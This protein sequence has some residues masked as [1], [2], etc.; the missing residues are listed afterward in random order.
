MTVAD[1]LNTLISGVNV[2]YKNGMYTMEEAYHIYTAISYLN[3]LSQQQEAPAEETT[4][5]EAQEA[6]AVQETP[7][8][9][10]ETP[11]NTQGY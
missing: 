9:E 8:E 5:P 4:A 7:V 2:A 6:P 3:S 10:V 1:A 11:Q